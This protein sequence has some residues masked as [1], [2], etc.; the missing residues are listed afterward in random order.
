MRIPGLQIPS[1]FAVDRYSDAL[2]CSIT[3]IGHNRM[4]KVDI[5]S[6]FQLSD[7]LLDKRLIL[8]EQSMKLGNFPTVMTLLWVSDPS[9]YY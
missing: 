8:Y 2:T 1:G 9:G 4:Q 3:G 5:E 7:H 6:W